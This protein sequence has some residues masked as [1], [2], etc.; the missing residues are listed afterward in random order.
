M[1]FFQVPN[2]LGAYKYSVQG[3]YLGQAE[4]SF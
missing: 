3:N 4:Y 2:K 1:H